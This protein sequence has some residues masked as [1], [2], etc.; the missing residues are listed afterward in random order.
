M[1]PPVAPGDNEMLFIRR[2]ERLLRVFE[3]EIR[4]RKQPLDAGEMPLAARI[5]SAAWRT[6][7][8][9]KTRVANTGRG[10]S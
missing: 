7:S 5:K 1:R 6:S 9:V 3:I 4:F 2:D 10:V 8:G